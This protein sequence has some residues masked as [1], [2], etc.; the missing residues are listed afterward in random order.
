MKA[1]F[2]KTGGVD[3][4]QFGDYPTPILKDDEVLISVKARALNHLDLW[5]RREKMNPC[6]TSGSRHFWNC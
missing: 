1:I 5:I 4:L 2:E 3:V 6:H